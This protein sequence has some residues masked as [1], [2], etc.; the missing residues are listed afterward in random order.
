MKYFENFWILTVKLG[1][2][3]FIIFLVGMKNDPTI[4]QER[5]KIPTTIIVVFT[6]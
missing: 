2:Q 5:V 1:E 6:L 3:K 4:V